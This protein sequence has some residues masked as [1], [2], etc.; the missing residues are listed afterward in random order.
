MTNGKYQTVSSNEEFK[1]YIETI[2]APS[3]LNEDQIEKTMFKA[4]LCSKRFSE[5]GVLC[6][7]HFKKTDNYFICGFC[8]GITCKTPPIEC[9]IC[10][11]LIILPTDISK[12]KLVTS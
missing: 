4:T 6:H 9:F 12:H 7:C 3:I 10:K 1:Q 8:S 11:K 5:N 2:S